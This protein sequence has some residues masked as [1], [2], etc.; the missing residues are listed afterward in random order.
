MIFWNIGAKEGRG[1]W[2]QA[3]MG[4]SEAGLSLEF[5]IASYTTDN[6]FYIA[7]ILKLVE[8]E[9]PYEI[10]LSMFS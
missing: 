4:R 10:S 2:I 6:E 5:R 3:L 7:A 1:C 9:G 8:P